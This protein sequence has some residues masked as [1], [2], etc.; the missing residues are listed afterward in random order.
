MIEPGS[1][2]AKILPFVME[3]ALSKGITQ[4][5]D[6]E[7]LTDRGI[8]NSLGIFQLVWFLEETFAIRI[9]DEEITNENFDSIRA[10]ESFVAEKLA[11]SRGKTA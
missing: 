7:S 9:G 3:N 1:I 11:A 6:D 5:G 8:I 2:K 10:I 4:V